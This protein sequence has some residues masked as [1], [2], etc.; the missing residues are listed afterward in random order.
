VFS[1]SFVART[2][3]DGNH[4]MYMVNV[5]P[6]TGALSYDPS[7]KDEPTGPLGVAFNRRDWP[8]NAGAGFYKPHAMVWVCPPGVCPR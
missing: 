3:V 8:F 5:D 2:G 1:D 6:A 7:F 4:R